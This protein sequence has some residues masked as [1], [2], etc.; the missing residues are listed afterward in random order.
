MVL[1]GAAWGHGSG[2]YSLGSLKRSDA[3]SLIRQAHAL[4]VRFFDTAPV[5][6]FGQSE[7]W[8]GL[9]LR[10]QEAYVQT[11]VGLLWQGRRV[12]ITHDP[13]LWKQSIQESLQRLQRP[14]HTLFWHWPDPT[15]NFHGLRLVIEPFLEKGWIQNLGLSNRLEPAYNDPDLWKVYQVEAHWLRPLKPDPHLKGVWQSWGTL[16]HGIWTGTWKWDSPK[17]PQDVR[18]RA[19]FRRHIPWNSVKKWQSL[20]IG[21]AQDWNTLPA[22]MA[23]ALNLG[24]LGFN[25]VVLGITSPDQL[26]KWNDFFQN[27]RYQ[28]QAC[29][30]AWAFVNEYGLLPPPEWQSFSGSMGA[31]TPAK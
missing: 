21:W 15:Q 26:E 16:G 30:A 19:W 2:G 20:W 1:G 10:N 4:G 8:L 12:F 17:S 7:K 6:G 22:F 27:G 3:L 24:V 23:V 25:Q 18:S 5:Y 13:T 28:K 31:S 9:A 14:I 11:K 29:E